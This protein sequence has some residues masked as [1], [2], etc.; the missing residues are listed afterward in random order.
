MKK[1]KLIIIWP[2]VFREFDYYRLEIDFLKTQFDVEVHELSKIFYPNIIKIYNPK[3]WCKRK[4]V[5]KY[6][7]VFQWKKDFVNRTKNTKSVIMF[8][9]HVNSFRKFLVR[10]FLKHKNYTIINY[11]KNNIPIKSVN[12]DLIKN[13][14]KKNL[15]SNNIFFYLNSIFFQSI[16]NIIFKSNFTLATSGIDHSIQTKKNSNIFI[17]KASSYDFS[18][19]LIYTP[20]ASDKKY[21]KNRYSLFI[22]TP[23]PRYIGDEA[24][25]RVNKYHTINKWYPSLNKFFDFVE[26]N[27]K[28][29]IKIAPHPKTKPVKFS[30]DFEYRETLFNRLAYTVKNAKIIISKVPGSTALIYA[31]MFNKPI[32]FIYSNEM[33]EHKNFMYDFKSLAAEFK[34]NPINIDSIYTKKNISNV[35]KM[36]K[37]KVYQNYI[38]KY[39]TARDD[40][41]SNN[42]ILKNLLKK[43]FNKQ[44]VI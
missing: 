1:N 43:I 40:K 25:Y 39:G 5:R 34:A 32:L 10:L 35:L 20:T 4:L 14:I 19:A 2:V 24:F 6:S 7:S 41:I 30:K 26:K 9:F 33:I 12:K 38:K 11:S 22:D 36:K 21:K 17:E 8:N 18:N 29:Q 13:K 28:T 42:I 44:K 31:A 3:T 37:N 15:S 27:F 23:G 16:S